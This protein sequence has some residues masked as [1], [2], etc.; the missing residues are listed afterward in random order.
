[1]WFLIFA[2]VYFVGSIFRMF[3]RRRTYRSC[4][5]PRSVA[6]PEMQ[7][8]SA[9]IALA[10]VASIITMVNVPDGWW[11]P[12]LLF[13]GWFILPILSIVFYA[14]SHS[15][16]RAKEPR[17]KPTEP[18]GRRFV[19]WMLSTISIVGLT[20]GCC[21]ALGALGALYSVLELDGHWWVFL[22]FA[23]ASAAILAPS[24]WL[25]N[26]THI[27][28]PDPTQQMIELPPHLIEPSPKLPPDDGPLNPRMY[29]SD[30]S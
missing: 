16:R 25:Y 24:G 11:S 7:T 10:A 20:L 21:A 8:L 18:L 26:R 2:P 22:A 29:W 12:I 6:R 4:A 19:S 9:L 1:M 15:E 5:R 27:M 14:M 28:E 13:G 30:R 17:E 23:G 3:G